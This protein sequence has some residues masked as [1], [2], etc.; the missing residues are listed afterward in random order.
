[1]ILYC[2]DAQVLGLLPSNAAN[3]PMLASASLRQSN[4]LVPAKEWIDSVYPGVA[5]FPGVGANSPSGWQVNQAGHVAGDLVVTVDQGSG[6]PAIDDQFQAF[7][8]GLKYA[9]NKK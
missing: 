4:M 2:T 9:L 3:S 1:M 5:P 7:E 8:D 6:D